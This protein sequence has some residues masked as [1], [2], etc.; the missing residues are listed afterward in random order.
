MTVVRQ[1]TGY[2][3]ATFV[4]IDKPTY[5]QQE[6]APSVVRV[7]RYFFPVARQTDI[8]EMSLRER[9]IIAVY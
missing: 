3:S 5:R 9:V 7:V 2:T 6:T 4:E 1:F 8:N